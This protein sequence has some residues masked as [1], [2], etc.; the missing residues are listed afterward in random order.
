MNVG[1]IENNFSF[2]GFGIV[3]E[4]KGILM[5]WSTPLLCL[6]SL[7]TTASLR[8]YNSGK[9]VDSTAYEGGEKTRARSSTALNTLMCASVI[10]WHQ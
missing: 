8:H 7:A 4:S 1:T 10:A 5:G 6:G 2:L 9:C 3:F